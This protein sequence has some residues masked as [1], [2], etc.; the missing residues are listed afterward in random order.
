MARFRA[1]LLAGLLAGQIEALRCSGCGRRHL[2]PRPV[3][4]DC[5]LRLTEWVPVA[6][7]GTLLA[8]TVVRVPIVDGRTGAPRPSPYGMGLIR[9]DGA[10]PTINHYLSTADPAELTIGRRVR[11]RWRRERRGDVGDIECFELSDDAAATPPSGPIRETNDQ[12]GGSAAAPIEVGVSLEFRYAAGRVVGRFLLA[13][14][15]EGRLLGGRCSGCGIVACPPRPTCPRCGEE[16][17]AF[18]E[19]GPAGALTSWTELP[20]GRV[21]GLVRLDG[22]DTA[23]LHR[24]LGPAASWR[25]GQRVRARL[26]DDRVGSVLDIRGFERA[27]A[28]RAPS[29]PGEAL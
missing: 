29:D 21:L 12:S 16:P 17:S 11:A 24:L 6:D 3:C 7:A 10:D 22:A 28:P 8:Y 23:T 4:G 25:R 26:A 9:L 20:D 14:R 15:D 1:G 5:N 2:P 13:L 18:P 19:V 27:V